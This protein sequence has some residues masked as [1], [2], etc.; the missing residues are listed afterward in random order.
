MKM[1][2]HFV[3]NR[4]NSVPQFSGEP[5]LWSGSPCN[6]CKKLE[7]DHCM[8]SMV[9][10]A[11]SNSIK[12][13]AYNACLHGVKPTLQTGQLPRCLK[14]SSQFRKTACNSLQF[15]RIART[16]NICTWLQITKFTE[17]VLCNSTKFHATPLVQENS[18]NFADRKIMENLGP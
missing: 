14:K 12:W 13:A 5:Q 16:S 11:A 17:P 3:V 10:L 18:K 9:W 7:L 6:R 15:E 1:F 2:L 8:Q 4:P